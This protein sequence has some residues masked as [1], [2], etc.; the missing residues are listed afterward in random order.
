MVSLNGALRN[1]AL[2]AEFLYRIS[3]KSDDKCGNYEIKY[4]IPT[5]ALYYNTKW[6]LQIQIPLRF[7]LKYDYPF[8]DF[9]LKLVVTK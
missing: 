4:K 3:H 2:C 8:S 9:F 5:N 7:E 6:K 1:E